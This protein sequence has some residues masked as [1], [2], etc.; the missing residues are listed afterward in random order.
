M[1]M[2]HKI[3]GNDVDVIH[4][5]KVTT[6]LDKPAEVGM[7]ILELSKVVIYEFNYDYIKNKYS[8]DSRLLFIDT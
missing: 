5:S 8:N 2:L 6:M 3:F 7:C 1:H 4:K